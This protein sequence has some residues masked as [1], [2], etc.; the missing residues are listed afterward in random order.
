[1]SKTINDKLKAAVEASLN[2]ANKPRKTKKSKAGNSDEPANLKMDD[3]T[4]DYLGLPRTSS[5]RPR[6]WYVYRI[7]YHNRARLDHVRY[8][9][10][11]MHKLDNSPIF[12]THNEANKWCREMEKED[13]ANLYFVDPTWLPEPEIPRNVMKKILKRGW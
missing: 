3:A 5:Q 13:S 7:K 11:R 4:L 9:N 1:M 12:V 6:S 8:P 2:K 10:E